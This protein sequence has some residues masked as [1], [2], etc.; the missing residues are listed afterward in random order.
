MPEAYFA[1]QPVVSTTGDGVNYKTPRNRWIINIMYGHWQFSFSQFRWG[2]L[3][4]YQLLFFKFRAGG[5][6]YKKALKEHNLH[7]PI[8]SF[9]NLT[10]VEY[11]GLS[12]VNQPMH[13]IGFGLRINSSTENL[14]E[15]TT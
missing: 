15:V 4:C 8:I 10:I 7:L 2:N 6:G 3:G 9:D 1:L 14:N 12:I 13:D 11:I 5:C